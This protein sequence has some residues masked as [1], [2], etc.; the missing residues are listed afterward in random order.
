[1]T[2]VSL[3]V[4]VH[5]V[6]DLDAL[7]W[8]GVEDAHAYDMH[9]F[10]CREFLAIWAETVGVARAARPR[11]VVVRRAGTPVMYLPLCV[12]THYGV[13]VLRFMDGGVADFNAPILAKSGAPRVDEMKPL[14]RRI[15]RQIGGVDAFDFPHMPI[16]LAGTSNPLAGLATS[17]SAGIGSGIDLEPSAETYE[18]NPERRELIA[19]M[20]RKR[21][22]AERRMAL[23]VDFAP[24]A[25]RVPAIMD[26]LIAQKGQ[27]YLATI[28]V[29]AL[30]FPGIEAFFRRMS[31][32]GPARGLAHLSTLE[33]EGNIAAAH[34]GYVFGDRLYY[35][36]MAD[37][38]PRYAKQSCGT[39][40]LL[41]NIA[42]WRRREARLI[43]LGIGTEPW[44][45]VWRTSETLLVNHVSA[46]TLRGRVYVALR[47]RIA[48]GTLLAEVRRRWRARKRV[49]PATA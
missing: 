37:D 11:L 5:G 38:R 2:G 46:V 26:F 49:A 28:G 3:D 18:T 29:N 39:L 19:Q 43:D 42:W 7:G 6:D 34:L 15:A 41:E 4:A 23:A 36:L 35:I 25:D 20:R 40:L 1:M 13:R 16:H 21:H 32:E 17:A 47:R 27:Q 30:A 8:P 24:P 44:K 12:E 14:L 48:E 10:Q 22:Q 45:R 9:V 31:V 33:L